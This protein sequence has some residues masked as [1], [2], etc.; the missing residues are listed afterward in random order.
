[1]KKVKQFLNKI[2]RFFFPK[3]FWFEIQ[4]GMMIGQTK[5]KEMRRNHASKKK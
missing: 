2:Y 3:N 4:R 1:M 5:G